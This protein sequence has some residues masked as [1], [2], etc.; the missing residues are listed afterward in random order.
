MTVAVGRLLALDSPARYTAATRDPALCCEVDHWAAQEIAPMV[1][2]RRGL[3]VGQHTPPRS[4][5]ARDIY[6][7]LGADTQHA[8]VSMFLAIRRHLA[9]QM[10]GR[11]LGAGVM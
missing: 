6:A 7:T 8:V 10:M 3:V 4:L 11:H 2:A 1:E 5:K 9:L